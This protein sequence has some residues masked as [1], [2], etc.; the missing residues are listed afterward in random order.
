MATY[1]SIVAYDGT[2]FQGFQRLARGPRTVQGVLEDALRAVGWTG[3]SLLAAGRTDAGVHA[4]GQVVSYELAWRHPAQTLSRAL[5]ANLPQDVAVRSTEPAPE[6]FHPRFSARRRTYGYR[7]LL[8]AWPDP[9]AERYAWRQSPGPDPALMEPEAR[10]LIGRHD[11]AAFGQAP[12]PGG[13]TVREVFVAR[14]HAEPKGLAFEIQ[15]NAFL[16][17]MVRRVVAALVATGLGQKPVGTLAAMVADPNR[18]WE[19]KLAPPHGL[20][21][22]AV[23]Y[24]EAAFE[25]NG[26]G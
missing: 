13:H 14:W 6:G 19:D 7:I 15:A 22:E 12:I 26:S 23:E 9:L 18:R 11:F 2:A 10:A 21:L 4:R 5:N 25:A 8:D 24:G 16:Q 3:T 17:H 1:K 20:C